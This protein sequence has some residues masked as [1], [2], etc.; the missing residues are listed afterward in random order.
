MF[1]KSVK[2]SGGCTKRNSKLHMNIIFLFFP[3][4]F[5]SRLLVVMAAAVVYGYGAQSFL[6]WL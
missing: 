1:L 2:C 5:L 6:V 4:S 3:V